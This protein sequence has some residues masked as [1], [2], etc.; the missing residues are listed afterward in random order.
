MP[1][2]CT[3]GSANTSSIPYTGATQMSRCRNSS[4]HS[5]RPFS[6]NLPRRNSNISGNFSRLFWW[7]MNSSQPRASHSSCQNHGSRQPMLSHLPS[8]V[9]YT[10]EAGAASAGD[11]DGA[12]DAD[13]VQVVADQRGVGP[14][15]AVA[16]E[17]AVDDARVD[18]GHGLV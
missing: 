13:V 3:C 17:G 7:G 9:S 5:S 18:R 15:L 8:A 4:N 11:A 14:G 1:R 16:A 6:R 12:A 10:V 2:A